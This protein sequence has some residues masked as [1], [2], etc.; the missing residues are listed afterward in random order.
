MGTGIMNMEGPYDAATKTIMLKGKMQ[1]PV[2]GKDVLMR[3]ILKI[4]DDK[5][6]T[7]EMYVV[8]AGGSESKIMEAKMVKK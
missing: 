5:N 6:Q 3:E 7:M 1:D 2:S 4:I 8:P